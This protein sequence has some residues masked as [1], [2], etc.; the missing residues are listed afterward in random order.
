MK[1][2][3]ARCIPSLP[4]DALTF[5]LK[6]EPNFPKKLLTL[7][8][9]PVEKSVELSLENPVLNKMNESLVAR[10]ALGKQ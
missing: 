8:E 4:L 6:S 2:S 7:P 10:G 9:S 1:S 3:D 5:S